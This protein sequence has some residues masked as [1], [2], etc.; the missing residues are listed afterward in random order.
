MEATV[1]VKM[2]WVG[3]DSCEEL[4]QAMVL[5]NL[6]ECPSFLVRSLRSEM[7][8]VHH[9]FMK[10]LDFFSVDRATALP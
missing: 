9:I 10:V 1:L 3:D 8:I 6:G 2:R 7:V 4:I 5:I